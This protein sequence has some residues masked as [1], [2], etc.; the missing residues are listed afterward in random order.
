MVST[1]TNLVVVLD[2]QLT[3]SKHTASICWSGFYKLR[4]LTADATHALVQAFITYK[5]DYYN[6]L[7]AGVTDI[8]LRRIQSVQNATA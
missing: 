1:A 6:S 5:L 3:M 8:H 4:Q 2:S 7:L